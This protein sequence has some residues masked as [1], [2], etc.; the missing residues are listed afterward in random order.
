MA[1][2]AL[3]QFETHPLWLNL[4]IF[5]V[6]SAIVWLAGTKLSHYADVISER[7]GLGQAF[8]G[9]LLLATATSLP[10]I[11]TTVTATFI[12]SVPLVV[13]NLLGGV[14]MQTA[15]LALVDAVAVSGGALTRRTPKPA[16]LLHGLLLVLLLTI[17]LT[18]IALGGGPAIY[19]VGAGTVALFGVYL[20]GV[21]LAQRYE[22]NPRWQ[23]VDPGRP[24]DTSD[25]DNTDSRRADEDSGPRDRLRQRY[26]GTS[27]GRIVFYFCAGASA[28]LAAGWT[29]AQVG[30]ALAK[31][32]G[33]G[34]TLVGFVLVA[35]A[36]SLPEVST[37]FSAA[38]L[39]A[40]S[41]VFANIFG[42]NAFD[43]ALLFVADVLYRDGPVLAAVESWAVLAAALGIA[44]TCVYL[45]GLVERG[46]RTIFRMGID[47]ALVIVL[48]ASGVAALYFIR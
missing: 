37:T 29:I 41:M 1:P 11:A 43:A 31:Q 46:D 33:I 12:G 34:G 23:A 28:I 4:A 32:T 3:F 24:E 14:S 40:F 20:A 35:V 44:M 9:L 2:L 7:T 45:W 15:V 30:D 17:A 39:G 21:Y 8:V 5:A 19:H 48:Y 26:R 10:E 13:G 42:G 36:T 6:A 25:A 22:R 38:R 47:S 16:L 18:S 27:L